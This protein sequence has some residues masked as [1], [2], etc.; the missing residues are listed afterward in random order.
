MVEASSLFPS[1]FTPQTTGDG[2]WTFFSEEFGELF[3]SYYGAKQEAKKKFVEPTRLAQ[4]ALTGSVNLLDICYGL[5][6]NS[7]SALETLWQINPECSVYW[8][9]LEQDRRVPQRAIAYQFHQE[10]LDPIGQILLDLAQQGSAQ[11]PYFQGQ[12]LWGDARQTLPHVIAQ[13][14]QADAIFLDPF[15]PPTCPQLWTVEFLSLVA[16]VLKP[17]GDLATYSCS[18]AVRSALQLAGF[19]IGITV[20]VGRRSPGTLARFTSA[21]LMPLSTQEQEH[22]HTRAA[23]PYRDPTLTDSAP[24]IHQRRQ[25]EQETT[26]LEPTSHWKKRWRHPEMGNH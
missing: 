22:L 7:A 19:Q 5:G 3:H 2:S 13:G 23:I 15:S 18:A 9:G 17:D 26:T 25:Q 16:Q 6:Y 20:P 11:T 12:L 21:H 14:F 24:A 4:K 10:W 1:P 8:V